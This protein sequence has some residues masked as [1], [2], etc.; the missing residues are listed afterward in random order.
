MKPDP[1][2]YKRFMLGAVLPFTIL[3]SVLPIAPSILPPAL[4]SLRTAMITSSSTAP[5]QSPLCVRTPLAEGCREADTAKGGTTADERRAALTVVNRWESE[6][7]QRGGE[8]Q[9]SAGDLERLR[10]ALL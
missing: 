9:V 7:R 8:A 2:S 3:V 4:Q 6:F 1:I 5:F 10:R